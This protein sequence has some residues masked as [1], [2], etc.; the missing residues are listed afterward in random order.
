MGYPR[1]TH[2]G[3]LRVPALLDHRQ[4]L[5]HHNLRALARLFWNQKSISSGLGGILVFYKGR[6][7]RVVYSNLRPA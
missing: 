6:V 7:V 4:Q 3:R 2:Q 1:G 5:P